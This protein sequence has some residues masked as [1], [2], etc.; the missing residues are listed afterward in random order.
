MVTPLV[1]GSHHQGG[2][3]VTPGQVR[4][5]LAGPVQRRGLTDRLALVEEANRDS[6]HTAHCLLPRQ[7][8]PDLTH[9]ADSHCTS[10]RAVA[11]PGCRGG[12]TFARYPRRVPLAVT[13][14]VRLR[15]GLYALA[16]SIGFSAAV[17]VHPTDERFRWRSAPSG[18]VSSPHYLMLDTLP[19]LSCNPFV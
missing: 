5:N 6:S 8:P 3:G 17:Q 4:A 15:F 10:V 19:C 1:R 9:I 12:G 7:R 14:N 16:L 2:T 18:G 11:G 13:R